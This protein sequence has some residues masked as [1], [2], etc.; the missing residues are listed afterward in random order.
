M[1]EVLKRSITQHAAALEAGEYSSLELTR[2]FLE[3]ID[4][5]INAYITVSSELA[6]KQ[7][8]ESDERRKEGRALGLLDGIPYAA[9]DNISAEGLRLSCGSRMLENYVA[10]YDATVIELLKNSGAV[11]LGKTNL[12]EFA[13]GTGSETSCFGRVKNPLDHSR[14]AGGSSGGSAAAV[15]ADQIGRAHV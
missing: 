14:V 8:A 6:L 2:A 9:K 3:N 15:A 11:L 1:K 10:P 4:P 13:M 12:D 7:A 5:D